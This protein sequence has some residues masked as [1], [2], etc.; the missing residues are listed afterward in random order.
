MSYTILSTKTLNPSVKKEL[1][2]NGFVLMEADFIAIENIIDQQAIERINNFKEGD[3]IIFTSA[4]AV[5]MAKDH[6][7]HNLAINVFCISGK[8]KETVQSLLPKA[9]IVDATS[10]GKDLAEKIINSGVKQVLFLCGDIRRDELPTLLQQSNIAVEECTVYRT[11]QT[12]KQINQQFDAALFFSPS[13]V[14][15]FFLLNKLDEATV[16]FSIG[17]TTA[18]EIKK[19]TSNKTIIADAPTQEQIAIHLKQYFSQQ[20]QC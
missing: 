3:T 17:T 16:C 19:Y 12:P 9:I 4:N 2:Q 1:E 13:A 5:E 15:S 18:T 10:Y 14:K 8:T 7:D 20:V 11:I 6:L